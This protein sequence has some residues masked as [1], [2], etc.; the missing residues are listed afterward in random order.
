MAHFR[1]IFH[2]YRVARLVTSPVLEMTDYINFE[3]D[4]PV[5]DRNIS[6]ALA[7][8]QIPLGSEDSWSG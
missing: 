2:V 7:L 6:E 3:I 4:L 1:D 5:T 8:H